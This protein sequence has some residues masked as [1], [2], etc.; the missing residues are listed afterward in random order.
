MEDERIKLFENLF[1]KALEEVRLQ[2][3][4]ASFGKGS[5]LNRRRTYGKAGK[6]TYYFNN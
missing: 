1:D 3:E 6:K 4:R 5:L 2:Q